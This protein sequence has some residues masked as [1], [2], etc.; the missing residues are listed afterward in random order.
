MP[1]VA[2]RQNATMTTT[3]NIPDTV[4]LSDVVYS[5]KLRDGLPPVV[6]T[7]GRERQL[8]VSPRLLR[9][10]HWPAHDSPG[11]LHVFIDGVRIRVDGT[12]GGN[13]GIPFSDEPEQ[14]D[15]KVAHTDELPDWARTYLE[16]ARAWETARGNPRPPRLRLV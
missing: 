7:E 13:K 10:E 3:V 12:L 5:W 9:V 8:V 4:E 14:W 11:A 1:H 16:T 2:W 6:G 15:D